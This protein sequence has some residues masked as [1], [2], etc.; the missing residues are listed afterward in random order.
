M[1]VDAW[2]TFLSPE[3]LVAAANNVGVIETPTKVVDHKG[4]LEPVVTSETVEAVF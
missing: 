2:S 3:G 4:K 1:G